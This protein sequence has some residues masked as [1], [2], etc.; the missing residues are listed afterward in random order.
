MKYY[1]ILLSKTS[2]SLDHSGFLHAMR[3]MLDALEN[4][5][6]ALAANER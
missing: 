3:Q 2:P 5:S 1:M 4:V 6:R